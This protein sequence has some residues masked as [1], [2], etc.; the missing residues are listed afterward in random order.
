MNA[1]AKN[2]S[3][4]YW[5]V[6]HCD[7]WIKDQL[8]VTYFP[9]YLLNMFRTLIYP[10]SGACDYSF[11]LPHWSYCS[12]FDVCRSFGVVGLEWYPCCRL[13]PATQIWH[14][15]SNTHQ[16]KNNTTNVVVQQNS[17]KLLMMDILMSETCWANK[18]GNKI[19]SDIKLVFYSSSAKN[20][21]LVEL[22]ESQTFFTTHL[23]AFWCSC[24]YLSALNLSVPATHTHHH[25]C[26][27]LCLSVCCVFWWW[28]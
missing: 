11:E 22:K 24:P 25:T 17:R 13:Q 18:K 9:S 4:V 26:Q 3:Y 28:R 10:S 2:E 21:L 23:S 19:A 8:D 1:F 5:T 27:K 7:S 6:R 16:T 14:R 12:W 20:G 15:N